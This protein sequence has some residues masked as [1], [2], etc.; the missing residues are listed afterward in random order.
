MRGKVAKKIRK[1]CGYEVHAD[2]QYDR[3]PKTNII[4]RLD[5]RRTYNALKRDYKLGADIFGF[6][7]KTK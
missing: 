5:K 1:I 4:V 2:K 3:H 7:G 6:G